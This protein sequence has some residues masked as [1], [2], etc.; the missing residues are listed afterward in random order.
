[1]SEVEFFYGLSGLRLRGRARWAGA[2]IAL[3]LVIPIE[4]VDDKP[5][6]MWQVL[7]E[8]PPAG[9]VA[10][11]APAAAG[12]A[13]VAASLLCKRTAS[14][15][16]G[17]F[18]ALACAL[19]IIALG[20]ESS[21]WGVLPLPESLTQ[22]PTP[23]LLALSLTAAGADLSFKE[24][25]RKVAKGLLLAA[26]V[27]AAVFYLW[28]GKGEAPI[29]TLVRAL[30]GMGSLPSWRF[31]LGFVIVVLLVVWPGLM[32]LIGLVHLWIPPSREQ[33]ITGIAAV[34]ALPAMLMML[35]YRSLLGFQGG[36]WIVA[37]AGSII[38]L[39][40]LIAVTASSIEVLAER[41][42]VRD[43]DIEEPKGWPVSF[44]ALAGLGAFIVLCTCQWL[45]ARPP[46][47]GVAWTLR[48]PSADGD[49]LFG[50]LVQQWSHARASWDRRVRHDSSATA[51]VQTKAAAREMVAAARALDPGLGEAFTQLSVEADDLDVAGRRWYRLVA[52]VNEASRRAG[53]PYYV[54]PR[55]AVHHA[56][57]GLQRRFEAEAFRIER[58]KR[59][60]VSGKPFATLH[61]RQIGKPRGGL[62]Y[63]GLSRDVQ[64]FAL[65]VLDEL[66]PYEKEL[67]ELS[68]P[69][70]PRCG[71]SN[72]PGAQVGLRRCGDM[73]K[74]IVQ[75]SPSGLKAAILAATERHELQHQIDGPNLPICGE[76]LRRMGAFSKE[77]QMRVNRELS[78]YL[79]ELTASGAPPRLGLVHLLRFALVAKGGA[80]HYVGVQAMELMTGRDLY[81]WDGRPDPERVSEA[82]VELAGWPE[83][84]LRSK[85][86]ESWKKCFGERLPKIDPQDPG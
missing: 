19:M 29:A 18:A 45:V 78:G 28:P 36:A 2:I 32:A 40:A 7:A 84:K 30:I 20:A 27:V 31:Q 17:V 33:P 69:D 82:F 14:I 51:M 75:A 21:A 12:L 43:T 39:A 53:L 25:T 57:E 11:F 72:E 3:S 46:A 48:E 54:D 49:R 15:A 41:L 81:G 65:V 44:S 1:M 70:V 10:A 8:L 37:S 66:D 79:A 16:I 6:F 73:M 86:A 62:P 68:K 4:V 71:E 55:L 34:Y 63:L 23:V 13:I 56:G 74:E 9:L 5:Q 67:V 76:V 64:P 59:F 52:D 60:S 50:T 58:V 24:H 77:A 42:L 35:V 83:D 47:K 38:L 85:A 61:V 80:E 22:R 26:V